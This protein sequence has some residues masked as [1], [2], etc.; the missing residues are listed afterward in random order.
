M[1]TAARRAG[2]A[3]GV[4]IARVIGETMVGTAA[5]FGVPP[6]HGLNLIDR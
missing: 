6:D 5:L 4:V 3:A 1:S 2:R